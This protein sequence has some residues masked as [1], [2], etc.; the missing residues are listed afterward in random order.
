MSAFRWPI[1]VYY[2]DTDAGGVV[3]HASYLRFFER[4]RTER[5]RA[6]G[7]N[8]DALKAS[9]GIVFAVRSLSID[10]IKPARLD[11]TA[12]VTADFGQLR[13]ASVVFVQE[14]IREDGERLCRAEV[15]VVCLGA[16]SFRPQAIPDAVLHA[17][18]AEIG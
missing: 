11:D 12:W 7:F 5:L 10:F 8:Q 6:L 17:F 16:E 3:Y 2:E 13:A 9:Q 18:E 14:M 1:R 4:A 15:K